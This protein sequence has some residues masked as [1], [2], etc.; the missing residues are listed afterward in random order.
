MKR[1]RRR[2]PVLE[3]RCCTTGQQMQFPLQ[4][5]RLTCPR[6]P[7]PSSLRGN[8]HLQRCYAVPDSSP[9]SNEVRRRAAWRGPRPADKAAALGS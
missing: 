1:A 8:H 7:L 2:L 6:F 4:F 3:V 9:N 5:S